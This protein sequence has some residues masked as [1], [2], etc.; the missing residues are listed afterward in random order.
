MLDVCS[1]PLSPRPLPPA[2]TPRDPTGWNGMVVIGDEPQS[3]PLSCPSRFCLIPNLVPKK[4]HVTQGLRGS[5]PLPS[6]FQLTFK[7]S[8]DCPSHD[9]PLPTS[10]SNQCFQS[11]QLR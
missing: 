11:S 8:W 4:P 1:Q 2:H 5:D 3:P 10:H 9:I 7:F 6:P